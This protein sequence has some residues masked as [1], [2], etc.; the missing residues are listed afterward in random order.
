MTRNSMTATGNGLVKSL[1][2]V[3][4]AGSLGLV[5]CG[6]DLST[7]PLISTS[8]Q[9][10]PGELNLPTKDVRVESPRAFK[11]EAM[12]GNA[13]NLTWTRPAQS[14]LTAIVTLDGQNLAEIPADGGVYVD[15]I[16]KPAGMHS[17]ELCFTRGTLSGR[18]AQAA[19]EIRDQGG[20]DGG[21]TD[22]R[23]ELDD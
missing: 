2:I 21:R 6:S 10:E 16:G 7:A 23:P 17:Y 20:N 8:A 4:A 15:T 11:A 19:V 18:H 1:M 13:V 9:D 5:G 12:G 14:G 3:I 22:D